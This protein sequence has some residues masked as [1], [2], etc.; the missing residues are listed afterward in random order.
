MALTKAQTSLVTVATLGVAPGGYQAELAAFATQKDA[1]AYI[2]STGLLNAGT[3][4]EFVLNVIKNL[5]VTPKVEQSE[6][7]LKALTDGTSRADAAVDF[8]NAQLLA[9]NGKIENVNKAIASTSTSK[10]LEALK[11]EVSVDPL[12]ITFTDGE[13]DQNHSVETD[14]GEEVHNIGKAQLDAG[15]NKISADFTFKLADQIGETDV[16]TGK[17]LSPIIEAQA[18]EKTGSQIVLELRNLREDDAS[19]TPLKSLPTEGF[20]FTMDGVTLLVASE[21]INAANTYAELRDAVEARITELAQGTD[22]PDRSDVSNDPAAYAKLATFKVELGNTFNVQDDSGA[23]VTGQQVVMTDSAGATLEPLAFVNSSD[24]IVDTGFTLYAELKEAAASTVTKLITTNLTAD[25]VG[26]GSQGGSVNLAGQS[27]SDKGVEEIKVTATDGVWFSKLQSKA[28]TNHLERIELQ[29]GSN[30]YFRVGTQTAEGNTHVVNLT[31]QDFSKAGLID[32]REVEASNAGST[33]INALVTDN[34]IARDY[35]LKDTGSWAS[36]NIDINYNLSSGRDVLNL[37]VDQDVMESTDTQVTINTNAGNDVVH[38]QVTNSTGA[39]T[40]TAATNTNWLTNQQLLNNVKVNAGDGNDQIVMSGAGNATVNAGTGDDQVRADNT[41]DRAVFVFNNS[42]TNISNLLNNKDTN[43]GSNSDN[44]LSSGANGVAQTY[45]LFK[46]VVKVTFQ[47]FESESVVIDSTNYKTSTLQINQAIKKAIAE[48]P[49]LSKLL[50]AHDNEGHALGLESL[51]DGELSL[52]DLD[53]TI[54]APAAYKANET[55]AE[56]AARDASGQQML[57]ENDLLNAAKAVDPSATAATLSASDL[58]NAA[59]T[60]STGVYATEFGSSGTPQVLQQQTIDFTGISTAPGALNLSGDTAEVTVG[61]LKVGITAGMSSAQIADQVA[62]ALD[63]QVKANGLV[64]LAT[65]SGNNLAVSEVSVSGNSVVI[66]GI[67]ANT[68]PT[69][70]APTAVNVTVA[71]TG[72]TVAEFLSTRDIS[73]NVTVSGATDTFVAK[74]TGAVAGVKTLDFSGMEIGTAGTLAVTLPGN[75]T[76]IYVDV[77]KDDGSLAIAQKVAAKL[78]SWT[79]TNGADA[80][81]VSNVAY[82]DE[83]VV[84]TFTGPVVAGGTV[85][86]A[87]PTGGTAAT[88]AAGSANLADTTA[89]VAASTAAAGTKSAVFDFAGLQVTESGSFTIAGHTVNLTAGM[90]PVAIAAAVK[91]AVDASSPTGTT[92]S[93]L[94]SATAVT[95]TLTP[96][97]DATTMPGMTIE[98]GSVGVADTITKAAVTVNTQY[99]AGSANANHDGSDSTAESDNVINLG[100][101]TDLVMMGTDDNSNDTLVLT[102]Y[103]NGTNT[104][105]NYDGRATSAGKDF[106]DLSAYVAGQNKVVLGSVANVSGTMADKAVAK[107]S[108]TAEQFATLTD[109]EM[110]AQLNGTAATDKQIATLKGIDATTGAT[111]NSNYVLMVENAG[112]PGEYKVFHLTAAS[113]ANSGK[114]ATAQT[115]ATLDFG[116]LDFSTAQT[117]DLKNI[118]T[119]VKLAAGVVESTSTGDIAGTGNGHLI[120]DHTTGGNV[121]L[122]KNINI[123]KLTVDNS[124]TNKVTVSPGK[125]ITVNNL[126]VDGGEFD[127]SQATFTLTNTSG[128]GTITLNSSLRVNIAQAEAI[129]AAKVDIL[130]ETG[131][132]SNLIVAVNDSAEQARLDA[133]TTQLNSQL[134]AKTGTPGVAPGVGSV[135]A[136]Q[137]LFDVDTAKTTV[138]TNYVIVDTLAN[139]AADAGHA[140]VVNA[141]KI[142]LSDVNNEVVTT[143]SS[144]VINFADDAAALTETQMQTIAT[145]GATLTDADAISVTEV[146][147]ANDQAIITALTSGSVANDSIQG[148][149]DENLAVTAAELAKLKGF[150]ATG[151]GDITVTNALTTQA[152]VDKLSLGT[153]DLNAT[154]NLATDTT[155]TA[156]A[157]KLAGVTATGT[158]SSTSKLVLTGATADN[159]DVQNV[160]IAGLETTVEL[161]A[162]AGDLSAKTTAA[163]ATKFTKLDLGEADVTATVSAAQYAKV[164]DADA[165]DTITVNTLDNATV[166]ATA[167]TDTFVFAAADTGVAITS[168]TAGTDKVDL[169]AFTAETATTAVVNGADF[170]ITTDKVYFIS[171]AADDT[172]AG[173][174]IATAVGAGTI[175][176]ATNTAYVV[177]ADADSSSIY[178]WTGDGNGDGLV[179][180]TLAL[181][182][183]VDAALVTTD[184][185]FA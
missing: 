134:K 174:S 20:A 21:A 73:G 129:A 181:I 185:V 94:L 125:T 35:N 3:D 8:A 12:T 51:V 41:G 50:A 65:G 137:D 48:S 167:A 2:A 92:S 24:V 176:D 178:K 149:A 147:A 83:K 175:T 112:N 91:A 163:D 61:T 75:T 126:V 117:L 63:A 110:L 58:S 152:E 43:T 22:I 141:K 170:T 84:L 177:I 31:Q 142:T 82:V 120:I 171:G 76:P 49:Q 86:A 151:T 70:L 162:A 127:V 1:A 34:V 144:N 30:G 59:N 108:V 56:K 39:G 130:S 96:S 11:A 97:T 40:I 161:A 81:S 139:V 105:V 166:A 4:A 143:N 135:E 10:D 64:G 121:V 114:F 13:K 89:Y 165:S 159:L 136:G 169:N 154:L 119:T 153:G 18:P 157:D 156:T 128:T 146:T 138:S 72:A 148:K 29:T 17:F 69:V 14:N 122:N 140:K 88:I 95:I 87:A 111:A 93:A 160:S 47:G 66:K 113:G 37:A 102:G 42:T 98:N 60:L 45:D 36:D 106:L 155:I 164:V 77:A 116:K 100:T 172:D 90:K 32:V 15:A 7:F 173:T 101:G 184:L 80:V 16:Y 26:Y 46:A 168:F 5:G 74:G 57:A 33:A 103:N 27:K 54:T 9:N 55:A 109:A 71:K 85:T 124:A 133:I 25:N 38:F 118:T 131:S 6:A 182:G 99:Q 150:A 179:N 78:G 180:D 53:I 19:S 52:S 104:V 107:T 79:G 67:P 28:E 23:T 183:T 115:V 62:R 132:A 44:A 158:N 123:P 145:A 68:G